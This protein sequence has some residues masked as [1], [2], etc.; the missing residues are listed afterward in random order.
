VFTV[1][2]IKITI[3]WYITPCRLVDAYC[4]FTGALLHYQRPDDERASETSGNFYENTRR[5]V[6]EFCHLRQTDHFVRI[7]TKVPVTLDKTFHDNLSFSAP[8]AKKLS[9]NMLQLPYARLKFYLLFIINFPSHSML[10]I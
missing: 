2:D 9:S 1:T 3:F 5:R 10:R 8:N 6:S 7:S 4:R